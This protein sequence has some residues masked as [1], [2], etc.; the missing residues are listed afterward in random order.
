LLRP[1]ALI[2][3]GASDSLHQGREPLYTCGRRQVMRGQA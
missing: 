3:S 2:G 1:Y